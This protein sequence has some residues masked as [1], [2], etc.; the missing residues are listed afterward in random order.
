[1]NDFRRRQLIRK[2][3]VEYRD[4]VSMPIHDLHNNGEIAFIVDVYGWT[5]KEICIFSGGSD[6]IWKAIERLKLDPDRY[7]PM[8][9]DV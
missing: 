6:P 5:K 7:Q 4:R 3:Q 9:W 8:N 2:M 1:M